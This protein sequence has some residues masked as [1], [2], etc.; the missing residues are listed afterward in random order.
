MTDEHD[1]YRDHRKMSLYWLRY[2]SEGLDNL[3]KIEALLPS[4]VQ[5]RYTISSLTAFSVTLCPVSAGEDLAAADA[6]HADVNKLF[7]FLLG[8]CEAGEDSRRSLPVRELTFHT[9]TIHYD[10]TL[11]KLP[12]FD[13][14]HVTVAG[15]PAG[16]ACHITSKV[17]GTHEVEDVEYE[18]VCDDDADVGVPA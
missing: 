3:E 6:L 4:F 9:D 18:M 16:S 11:T 1:A 15:L 17:T 13:K 2:A 5:R 12:G 8:K 7:V 14:L 10:F